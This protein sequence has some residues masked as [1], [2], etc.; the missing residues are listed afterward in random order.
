MSGAGETRSGASRGPVR[1]SRV[2]RGPGLFNPKESSWSLLLNQL[3]RAL[4]ARPLYVDCF[5]PRTEVIFPNKLAD[6][7]NMEILEL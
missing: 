4:K 5:C 1:A 7:L 2:L 6:P 3:V